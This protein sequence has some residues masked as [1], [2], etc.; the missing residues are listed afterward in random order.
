M[1]FMVFCVLCN[2]RL[3]GSQFRSMSNDTVLL[4]GVG[5]DCS[6]VVGRIQDVALS[7]PSLVRAPGIAPEWDPYELDWWA[8]EAPR[9]PDAAK[10]AT[11]FVL[12]LWNPY[13][14]IICDQCRRQVEGDHCSD[15]E[16]SD[17]DL[18]PWQCGVF[19]VFH[20]LNTW[21]YP[22]RKA[23]LRWATD[24]WLAYT[25]FGMM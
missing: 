16:S 6:T 19:D 25:A 13:G 20:A 10:H 5:T 14:Q 12:G 11:R 9:V 1:K 23:F 7:F 17:S 3:S 22:D 21:G 18:S 2:S 4:R 8:L 24:P 15:C